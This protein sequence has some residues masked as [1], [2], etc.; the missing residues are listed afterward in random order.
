MALDDNAMLAM[1]APEYRA[2][3]EW[4]RMQT[5]PTLSELGPEGA[6][7]LMRE[8]QQGDVSGYAV[9]VEQ[10]AV[11][12]FTVQ[13]VKPLMGAAPLPAV[14]YCHGG[15]W[16][17]GDFETHARMVREIAAQSG[18]AI[19]FV[20]YAR[21]PEAAFPLSVEQCY[22]TLEWAAENGAALGLDGARIAVAGDSA[23]GNLAAVVA[24]LAAKRGGPRICLQA[25]LYAVTDCDFE[26]GSYRDFS[27]GLNLDL[28]TMQWF[29][30]R[31]VPDAA[32]RVDPMASPL[33]AG[34]DELKG[35]AP[36]LVVTA[37]CDVL[38]D[39]GEAYARR[40]A[41]AGVAV[42]AVRFGG[43]V[44]AFMMVDQLAESAEAKAAMNLLC[45][46]LRRAFGD[47]SH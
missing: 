43:V 10:H 34:L 36:A 2:Y 21:A 40:L 26:T 8:M 38:R 18:A 9:T 32:R 13:I 23:G 46:E 33:R 44:H 47:A 16:V 17:L 35:V 31:Y 11:D 20:E 25:L 24:L 28:E 45:A 12:D 19:V 30:D 42:A 1:L 29:W 7:A 27:A 6:R 5:W 41:D 3:V 4:L 15:G 37:G 14:I 39:E 22:R